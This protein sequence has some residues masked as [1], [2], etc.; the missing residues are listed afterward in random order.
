MSTLTEIV[1][2]ITNDKYRV[3]AIHVSPDVLTVLAR[4]MGIEESSVGF[5]RGIPVTVN[6]FLPQGSWLKEYSGSRFATSDGASYRITTQNTVTVS[7]GTTITY[8]RADYVRD[9]TPPKPE[10]KPPKRII[11]HLEEE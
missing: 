10:P 5:F 2:N 3:V 7:G 1:E 8:D 11:T 6:P 9:Q 4:D